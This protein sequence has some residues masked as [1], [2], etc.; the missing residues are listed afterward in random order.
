MRTVS[1]IGDI[2]GIFM[3]KALVYIYILLLI[4][5][6]KYLFSLPSINTLIMNNNFIFK[7]S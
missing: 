7:S 6:I 4:I 1:L 2:H 3:Y 5:D